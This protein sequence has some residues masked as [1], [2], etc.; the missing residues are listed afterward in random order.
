MKLINVCFK[1]KGLIIAIIIR[2]FI[3]ASLS[4][5]NTGSRHCM[6]V[7][8]YTCRNKVCVVE[9]NETVKQSSADH[10]FHFLLY[11]FVIHL[12]FDLFPAY[13]PTDVIHVLK[14]C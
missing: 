13:V 9:I 5:R 1:I 2:C 11:L 6:D 4:V 12:F 3:R 7:Y 10:F 14:L 8:R